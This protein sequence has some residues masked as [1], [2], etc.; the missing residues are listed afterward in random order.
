MAIIVDHFCQTHLVSSEMIADVWDKSANSEF[1]Q[2]YRLGE[3]IFLI[4]LRNP[5]WFWKRLDPS[6]TSFWTCSDYFSTA[7]KSDLQEETMV[8]PKN[9]CSFTR[10]CLISMSHS[11]VMRSGGS[12]P[13][14]NLEF[15]WFQAADLS[16]SKDFWTLLNTLPTLNDDDDGGLMKSPLGARRMHTSGKIKA[17]GGYDPVLGNI[18]DTHVL[19][20]LGCLHPWCSEDP[21]T[22]TGVEGMKDQKKEV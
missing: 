21:K 10:K 12:C 20:S 17:V 14:W 8:D 19:I 5:Y 7:R 11:L 13:H 18:W 2:P 4:Y 16:K 1:R 6:A 22:G 3:V 9:N 15:L